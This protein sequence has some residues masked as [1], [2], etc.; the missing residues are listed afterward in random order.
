MMEMTGWDLR[1]KL[2]LY[3]HHVSLQAE[4]E[5]RSLMA[6]SNLAEDCYLPQYGPLQNMNILTKMDMVKVTHP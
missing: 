2:L 1:Y 6:I 3:C 5:G 4:E